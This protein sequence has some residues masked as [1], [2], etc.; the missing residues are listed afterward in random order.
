[1]TLPPNSPLRLSQAEFKR[2]WRAWRKLYPSVAAWLRA[3]PG[4][5]AGRA[6]NTPTIT[7]YRHHL[8]GHGKVYS[9]TTQPLRP[10]ETEVTAAEYAKGKKP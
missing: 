3:H 5:V 2:R 7:Y 8:A 6:L 4:E 9:W 1:M 10:Y